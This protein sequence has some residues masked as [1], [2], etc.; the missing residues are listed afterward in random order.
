MAAQAVQSLKAAHDE[1]TNY[2]READFASDYAIS[3]SPRP[4][5]RSAPTPPSGRRRRRRDAV[6]RRCAASPPRS[7]RSCRGSRT[8]A[9]GSSRSTSAWRRCTSPAP[10]P[11][12]PP[13]AD[14]PAHAR[15]A[16][17]SRPAGCSPSP[18]SSSPRSNT[19]R[20][21][22]RC[23][24][25][26][27]AIADQDTVAAALRAVGE[28]G[29]LASLRRMTLLQLHATADA[30]E[31]RYPTQAPATIADAAWLGRTLLLNR[32]RGGERPVPPRPAH[33][34]RPCVGRGGGLY[35]TLR[36]G[37]GGGGGSQAFNA[38]VAQ[39]AADWQESEVRARASR[40]PARATAR[41][42]R[43]Y[44]RCC[45]GGGRWWSQRHRRRSQRAAAAAAAA[46]GG[47]DEASAVLGRRRRT[48]GAIGPAPLGTASAS[49][50]KQKRP[51]P[52]PPATP[53]SAK[54]SRRV[55]PSRARATR[56]GRRCC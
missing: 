26:R 38:E 21:K 27:A 10:S 37:E 20:S 28:G 40:R 13:A 3:S 42:R 30:L 8:R 16:R 2:L 32:G 49:S 23:R 43:R 35:A 46:G 34:R 52:T 55:R 1:L 44:S 50:C 12:L 17:H 29:R 33:E 6:A 36:D 54:S 45:S 48:A 18:A 9:A 5:R 25:R 14:E 22:G 51:P 39:A 4:R 7:R 47:D 11:T 31:S 56:C 19:S 53:T 15:G 24:R 41:W